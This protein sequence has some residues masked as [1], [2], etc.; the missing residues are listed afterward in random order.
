M[1]IVNKTIT[2]NHPVGLHARPGARF[3]QTAIGFKSTIKITNLSRDNRTANAK[4]VLE[5]IKA[6]VANGHTIEIEAD[7]A[8]AQAA[9]DALAGL[10]KSNF[11][12]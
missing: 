1:A 10:I 7:G 4:S 11:G 5:V 2:V 6:A 8:D 3:V 12:E 9:V